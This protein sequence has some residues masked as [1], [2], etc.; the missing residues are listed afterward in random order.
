MATARKDTLL[1]Q[2]P[3]QGEPDGS[4]L[5]ERALG[6]Q[7]RLFRND[8]GLTVAEL[9]R[10]AGLSPGMLSKIENGQTSPSLSTVKNLAG[11]LSVPVTALFRGYDE[12]RDAVFVEAGKGLNIE[13]RGTRAGHQYQLLGHNPDAGI[14]VEPYLITLTEA[15]DV[16]PAVSTRRA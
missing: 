7:V 14:V 12:V 10:N 1:E 16:F 13:R 8:L 9:A 11:A 5:L 6:R 4:N 3:H 15:S 2:D